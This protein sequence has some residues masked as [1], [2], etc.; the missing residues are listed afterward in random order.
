MLYHNVKGVAS[1][2]NQRLLI[3]I[4]R[5]GDTLVYVVEVEQ[6]RAIFDVIAQLEIANRGQ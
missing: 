3:G 4:V 5:L 2:F 1:I 6:F